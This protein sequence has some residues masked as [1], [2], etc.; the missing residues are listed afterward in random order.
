MCSS[1]LYVGYIH[2]HFLKAKTIAGMF[3]AAIFPQIHIPPVI[4]LVKPHFL[5]SLCQY[6]Q[7]FFS[8]AATDDFADA[9]HQQITCSNGFPMGNNF[10]GIVAGELYSLLKPEESLIIF[11][12]GKVRF[13]DAHPEIDGKRA[14]RVPASMYYP[15]LKKPSDVCYIHHVYDREKDTEDSGEPQHLP[16]LH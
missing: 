13:G 3:Y 9:R 14:L 4:F 7:S 16:L 8:L 1:D 2:Y 6:I 12:S 11:H 10:L 15:K 5:H